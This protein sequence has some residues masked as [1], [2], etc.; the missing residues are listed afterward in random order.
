MA[1][2]IFGGQPDFGRARPIWANFAHPPWLGRFGKWLGRFW[3]TDPPPPL[4]TALRR[5]AQ[6]FA[7]FF[8]LSRHKIH[9]FLPSLGVF[10]CNFGGVLVGRDLK[11]PCFRLQAV[12]W[13]PPCG[14]EK[15]SAKFRA[16]HP[17]CPPPFGPPTLRAHNS[18]PP[19]FGP[20]PF[21]CLGPHPLGPPRPY[22]S[23]TPLHPRK[24]PKLTVAKV[25]EVVA[26]LDRGQ[27]R[28]WPNQVVAK[29]GRGQTTKRCWPKAVV[30]KL[31]RAPRTHHTT[32]HTHTLHTH[33]T[34]TPHTH[35]TYTH[36]IHTPHTH[37]HHTTHH[38]PNCTTQH[39]RPH[40]PHPTPHTSAI[41]FGQFRLRPISTSANFDF[42]QFLD[43]EF[44]DHKGWGPKGGAPKPPGF[45]TTAREPKRAHFRVPA[46]KNTTNIQREDTQRGKKRMNFAAGE[47]KKRA[48]FWAVQRKGGPGEGRS[49]EGRSQEGRSNQTLKP[50]PTHET[51]LWYRETSTH[52]TQTTHNTTQHN[53]TQHNTTQH[54]TQ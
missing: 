39:T 20:P 35:T 32:P 36:H 44:W 31:G 8:S 47:G 33:S 38:A 51:P 24:R 6:N 46:F 25:G 13:K 16:P 15:K 1:F 29:P 45:H 7:L 28:S 9:S 18:G 14:K 54:T 11:C 49:R 2:L 22:P 10:S 53:T 40:T 42:G 4:R 48:K 50:T 26:K 5:T 41:D 30:A 12:L 17:S 52:A 37:T 3:P 43:V 27:T 23:P 34:H 21:Q 19:P